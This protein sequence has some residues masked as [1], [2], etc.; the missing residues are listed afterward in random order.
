MK[1]T[2]SLFILIFAF[3]IFLTAC[4][5]CEHTYDNACDVSCNEC[6]AERAVT[7]DFAA[8][9]CTN[10]K[11]CKT[12]GKTEGE[13]LV[14]TPETD[15]GDCTTAVKCTH[16]DHVIT[17]AK[18]AHT[19]EADDG[20]CT[21][22][23]KCSNC[24]K[25]TTDAK[26]AHTPEADDGDCTTAV[27][28]THCDKVTTDAKAAHTP[29]ADDGDCTTAVKCT[30][31]DKVTTDAKAAHTP[32]ADDGDCTTAVKCSA[33]DKNAIEAREEHS[34][35]NIDGKCDY[36]DY[37]FDYVYVQETN[38][39]IVFTATGL[40]A[41]EYD[42]WRG[43]NMLL[44]NDIVLPSE[45]LFD[46]DGDGINDSNWSPTFVWG[47]IDGDG[48]SIT[49]MVIKVGEQD[50]CALFSSVADTGVVKNLSIIDADIETSGINVGILTAYNNGI[51]ENC[52]V[53]GRLY[54]EGNN[55][56]GIAGTNNGTI[57]ACRNDAEI[58][59]SVGGNGGIAGQHIDGRKVIAS[60][61][62]GTINSD[63]SAVAG[64]SGSFYGGSI[65]ASYSNATVTGT[66][67]FGAIAGYG[68]HNDS[69]PVS[70]Y[71]NT[72]GEPPI[73]GIG[74]D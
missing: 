73:Y 34:D 18:A 24:D 57:I 58:F 7:H 28:C 67:D 32:E 51:I 14:H 10:P 71:W 16:C 9:D 15:D 64:I 19:P 41:W 38:T 8:A 36:C 31:C 11:T 59:S 74:N 47:V 13:P 26:A 44:A 42:S 5:E 66:Y 45:M 4:G 39:Y 1:K 35:E 33:C 17:D 56:A 23:V 21:T 12:C 20:D 30:H 60:Y 53:S 68:D 70:N 29:E 6:N 22:A 69:T 50:D 2:L 54:V 48:Y 62:T 49:G 55:V 40:Y 46:L 25:V 27:K 61:N 63:D 37:K 52:S 3:C 72:P 43:P 65:I